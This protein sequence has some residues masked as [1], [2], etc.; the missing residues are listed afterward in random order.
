MLRVGLTGAAGSGKSTV[1]RGLARRGL[2]VVDADRVAHELY[3]PGSP[4]VARLAARFGSGIL[5]PSGGV[6]RRA[7]GARVFGDPEALAALDALVHPPLVEELGRRLAALEAEGE[8][9]AVVEAA[10]LLKWSPLELVHLVVGVTAPRE[11]RRARLVAGGLS[12]EAAD[13]RLDAQVGEEELLRRSDIVI[14]N[15]RGLDALDAK[16]QA[17][18]DEILRRSGGDG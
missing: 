17:L 15:D 11:S 10:L 18:A 13:R 14:G 12:P 7:L 9:A 8:P 5:D 3:V 1:A 2:P 4:L 6:D 16:I